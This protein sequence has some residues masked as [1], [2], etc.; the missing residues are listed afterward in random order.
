MRVAML[1]PAREPA[2]GANTPFSKQGKLEELFN[3]S[4]LRDVTARAL[5]VDLPFR[6]FDDYWSALLN[7]PGGAGAWLSAQ[8]DATRNSVRDRLR[9]RVIGSRADGPFTLHARAWAV[10]GIARAR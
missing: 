9:A 8:S 6:D 2:D 7:D 3:G 4:G 10:K 1:E 5:E